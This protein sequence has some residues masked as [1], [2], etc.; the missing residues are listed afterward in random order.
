MAENGLVATSAE[1]GR[2]AVV[3]PFYGRPPSDWLD[4]LMTLRRAGLQLIIV[5]NNPELDQHDF[6][7]DQECILVQN[8]NLG[9]I[10]GGLNRGIATACKVGAFWITL[11]DQD[12]RIP[13]SQFSALLSPFRTYPAA[14]LVVGPIIWDEQRQKCHGQWC[15]STTPF[16]RTSMLISSGTTFR[17]SDWAALGSYHEGLFIDFVDYAWCFRAQTRGFQ[18]LQQAEVTLT[19]QFGMEHPNRLCRSLGLQ[20][21]SPSRHFYSIRNL[22][23]LCL[24]SYIP[25]ELKLKETLKMLIKPWLWV[26]FEPSRLANT[27]AIVAG[28]MAPLPARD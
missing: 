11:L 1:S 6:L 22:R 10:A 4:Y 3:I 25:L 23:W 8:H 21:Y 20:L 2:H 7:P 5:D 14:R 17:S 27:K 26:L 12:S 13:A 18:L 16:Q 19:Q 28:L 24:Q 9:G 15:I